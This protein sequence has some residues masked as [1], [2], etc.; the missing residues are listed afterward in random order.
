[1]QLHRRI[2][3]DCTQAVLWRCLTDLSLQKQ[4][5]SQL[6]DET[7]DD[8]AHNGLGATSTI[9]IREGNGIVS[10]RCVVTAWEPRNRLAIQLSGGSFAEGMEMEVEYLLAP[11]DEGG[12]L[13]DYDVRVPLTGLV[14]KLLAPI[15]WLVSVN[16]A[17]RDLSKL[18]ALAPTV[19]A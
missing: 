13:L 11:G 17:R 15:I 1:M 7:P 19:S 3:I 8:P 5:I 10:Y 4:W 2:S 6:V 14:F 12:T 9:R 16:N 18:A